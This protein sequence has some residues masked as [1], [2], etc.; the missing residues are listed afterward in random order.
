MKKI[1]LLALAIGWHCAAFAQDRFVAHEWGTFTSVQGADGIQIEWN[2]FVP[3]EL[4]KFVYGQPHRPVRGG[5]LKGDIIA[6]QRMETP[7]I[8]FYSDTPRTVDVTVNLPGGKITEWY[9]QAKSGGTSI[10]WNDV[11][12]LT[13]AKVSLPRDPRGSHYYAARET[14]ANPVQAGKEAEKFLFYRG[15]ASFTAPLRVMVGGAN[16]EVLLLHNSG[17]EAL[18]SLYVVQIRNGSAKYSHF[19]S[20]APNEGRQMKLEPGNEMP[21]S[22]FQDKIGKTMQVALEKEGL[23]GP[24]AAAMVNTWRDSWFGEDGVRVLYVLSPEWTDRALPLAIQPAP[25][26][27]KRV[28]VG[29]AEVIFPSQEWKLLKQIVR[30]S[31]AAPEERPAIIGEMKAIGMGRFADAALRRLL[32]TAPSKDFNANAW[33]L[34]EA[35]NAAGSTKSL[36]AR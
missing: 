7:V 3:A 6:R 11:Q 23:Y 24:E 33:A 31:E 20:L 15:V 25:D 32:G 12:L 19:E 9:P 21:L 5:L 28:M 29:R 17:P 16:E 36:A 8:Y 1:I 26:E 22:D 13:G 10:K 4:P 14:T 35:A 27:I 2:P 34:F 30:Y 18:K